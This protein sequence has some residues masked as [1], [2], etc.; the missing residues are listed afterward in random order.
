[1]NHQNPTPPEQDGIVFGYAKACTEAARE[2]ADNASPERFIQLAVDQVAQSGL[3]VT[4]EL[5]ASFLHANLKALI[6]TTTHFQGQACAGCESWQ[7]DGGEMTCCNA[8]TWHN[9]IPDNPECHSK[10]A[11]Q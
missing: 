6:A 10:N 3:V 8:V 7:E 2:L 9:G 4:N 11:Q 5:V 1:M